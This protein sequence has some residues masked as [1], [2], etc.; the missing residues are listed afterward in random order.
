MTFSRNM[1]ELNV[2]DHCLQIVYR[3]A[4]HCVDPRPEQDIEIRWILS[5][6]PYVHMV[7]LM[8]FIDNKLILHSMVRFRKKNI[9]QTE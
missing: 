2:R 6:C 4:G 7:L 9:N 3:S 8:L 1:S 5:V